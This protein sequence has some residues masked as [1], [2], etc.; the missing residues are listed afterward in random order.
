MPVRRSAL[1]PAALSF[2]LV[3]LNASM[4]TTAL[5]SIGRDLTGPGL[6]WVLTGYSLVFALCLLPAGAWADRIGPA[7]AFTAGVSV[8]AATSIV[9]ALAPDLRVLLIA[10][11][12][13]GAAAAVVLPAG[14][15][16]LNGDTTSRARDVGRWAAAGAVALVVGSPLGGAVTSGL[17]WQATFWLNL[18]VSLIVLATAAGH[19]EP[20]AL[21]STTSGVTTLLRSA[22][23][24]LSSATGFALN[25]ASYG[26]IFV[27]TFLLQQE[28]GHS[29]WTTGLVF[30]PMTLLIIPANLAAGQL[31]ARLGVNRTM[32]LG[33]ALMAVGLLGLC[34][35]D[36]AIWQLTAWLLPIGAGAG[37]VAPTA[38]TLML[39]GVPTDRSGL[40][41]GLFNAARQLG[42]GAAPAIFGVLLAGAH[43]MTGFR[44]SLVLALIVIALPAVF[45]P[46]VLVACA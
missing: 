10:R 25:F 2:F 35:A 39:N 41:S 33:Q 28:L 9:C 37:L 22:P 15:S 11:A 3:T 44:I 20:A 38:T 36:T 34:F 14:L 21:A 17:G 29:A 45:R 43:F 16:L 24:L 42:S 46:R 26:A 23:V 18:P 27:V 30:V 4:T 13:Q 1:V 19:R 32:L 8:F 5:P 12:L 40:G 31:G 6:S 7:R